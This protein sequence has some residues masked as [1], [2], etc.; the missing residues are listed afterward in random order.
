MVLPVRDDC[1][2]QREDVPYGHCR[3]G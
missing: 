3:R 1:D 2:H